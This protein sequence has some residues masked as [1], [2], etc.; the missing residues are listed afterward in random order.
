MESCPSAANGGAVRLELER[1]ALVLS[2]CMQ[3]V[4]AQLWHH[5]ALAV[6][7]L[8]LVWCLAPGVKKVWILWLVAASQRASSYG[9]LNTSS[10]VSAWR[11]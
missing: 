8:S 3:G 11:E 1:V 7:H 10:V 2:L 4:L 5:L 6:A 9:V